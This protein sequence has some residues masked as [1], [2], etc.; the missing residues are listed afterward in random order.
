MDKLQLSARNLG[1]LA[2][3]PHDGAGAGP[4]EPAATQLAFSSD[5]SVS[6][7]KEDLKDIAARICGVC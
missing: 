4:L 7:Y 2:A 5:G 6:S 1:L 3:G